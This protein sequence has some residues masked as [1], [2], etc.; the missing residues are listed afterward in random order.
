MK[1][2]ASA[3]PRGA[4][5]PARRLLLAAAGSLLLAL[6][7]GVSA[8][9]TPAAR[10]EWLI[11]S[12]PERERVQMT[13]IW[14]RSRQSGHWNGDEIPIARLE[15]LTAG[16]TDGPST[17]VRFEI[18][19][20]A[21]TFV[22]EGRGG[23]GRGAGLFE[24]RLDPGF[25]EG[26]RRRGIG[27]PTEGQQIRLSFADAG[28]ALLD[29]LKAQ[30]YL[31]PTLSEFVLMAEHGV[32]HEYVSGMGA[33]GYRTG[34]L[35]GLVRA[36]DHGVD[37]HYIGGMREA[38][39]DG[40]TLAEL[41]NARDHGVSPGYLAEMRGFGHDGSSLAEYIQLRDHGV[42]AKF[43]RRVNDRLGKPVS[44]ERLIAIRDRG[45]MD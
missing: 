17:A 8:A 10:G 2:H 9:E 35:A 21:G 24:L 20:D 43:A 14:K 3:S 42:D 44:L 6:P 16:Q 18:R 45:E 28:F 27:A 15:G 32:D 12:R 25:A 40:L 29:E 1:T 31:T 4:P 30:Q 11:E 33:L 36:R 23:D 39:F 38:G 19:R 5:S 37:P 22:C 34:S 7:Y 26:L 13:F 41:I